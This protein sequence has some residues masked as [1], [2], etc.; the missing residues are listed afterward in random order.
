MCDHPVVDTST[1]HCD[2]GTWGATVHRL[3]CLT[4]PLETVYVTY[5]DEQ[6]TT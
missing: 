2:Y 4:C 1:E 3:R 6:V 5:D